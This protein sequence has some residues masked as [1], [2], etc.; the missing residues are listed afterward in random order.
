MDTMLTM[1]ERAAASYGVRY[2]EKSY[3]EAIFM[4]AITGRGLLVSQ[5][6]LLL[7]Q[8]RSRPYGRHLDNILSHVAYLEGLSTAGN[9]LTSFHGHFG[10]MWAIFQPLTLLFQS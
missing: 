5:N 9:Y 3:S 6:L 10:T 2:G 8:R 4:T 1:L 7:R